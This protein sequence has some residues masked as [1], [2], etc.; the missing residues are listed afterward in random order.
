MPSSRAEEMPRKKLA[1]FGA[2]IVDHLVS[3]FILCQKAWHGH[4]GI[5]STGS[6]CISRHVNVTPW[7][8]H[9]IS[10][11]LHTFILKF[12]LQ[13]FPICGTSGYGSTF[14]VRPDVLAPHNFQAVET[15]KR[16]VEPVKR[17][18]TYGST[19]SL[20]HA[21]LRLPA[22]LTRSSSEVASSEVKRILLMSCAISQPCRN[23]EACT[24][25]IRW[26]SYT[27]E[28][29]NENTSVAAGEELWTLL[30]AVAETRQVSRL[31]RIKNT[32]SGCFLS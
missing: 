22:S 30:S 23:A 12:S 19:C 24:S 32:L 17:V 18:K 14:S 20:V 2:A 28:S 26:A 16:R 1:S 6:S 15:A 25:H 13:V 3:H 31:P 10:S 21:C 5:L 9:A 11:L 27:L 29:F 8:P 7:L 4:T